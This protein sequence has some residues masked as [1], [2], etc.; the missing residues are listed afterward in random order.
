MAAVV[1]QSLLSQELPAHAGGAI[2]H[3]Q[4]GV[5]ING[6]EARDSSAVFPGDLIETKPGAS[7]DLRFEGSTVLLAPESV[8]KFQGDFLELD[9][10]GVSVGTS[11][12]FQVHVN[13][14]HVVPVLNNQW[15]EY[16]VTDLSGVVQVAAR[17]NDVYVEHEKG[18][19][20]PAQENDFSQRATVHE[21]HQ[22]SYDESEVCGTK[23]PTG[24]STS[25]SPKWIAAAGGAALLLYL[26]L[27]GGNG[28]KTQISP[29]SP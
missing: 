20:K 21:G 10:G 18:L 3:S 26:L 6:S 19:G 11:R 7:A 12:A 25:V 1:P 8:A 13:C 17:K 27:H 16:V 24:A 14:M 4:G 28:N 29:S 15:T 5:W 23:R 2:L 9:H 22:E